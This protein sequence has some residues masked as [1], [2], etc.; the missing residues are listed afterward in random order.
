MI[1]TPFPASQ[2]LTVGER[3]GVGLA[4]E[5][6]GTPVVT[7]LCRQEVLELSWGTWMRR[8]SQA[9][10]LGSC[11]GDKVHRVWREAAGC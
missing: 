1:T 3:A 10:G 4:R 9:G 6:A 11:L 2:W 5:S 8:Y 7:Q